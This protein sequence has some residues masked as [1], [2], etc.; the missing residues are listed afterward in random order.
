MIPF[1]NEDAWYMLLFPSGFNNLTLT[2]HVVYSYILNTDMYV[3]H[4]MDHSG[5]HGEHD[6]QGWPENGNYIKYR[7][8][9]LPPSYLS[10][11]TCTPVENFTL[12]QHFTHS[13]NGG[14][15]VKW[16]TGFKSTKETQIQT[17]L[18]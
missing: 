5:G 16:F 8:V 3:V 7:A 13:C 11:P 6:S 18:F 12:T 1:N 15:K 2:G 14:S 17:E 10:E 9:F 4:Y